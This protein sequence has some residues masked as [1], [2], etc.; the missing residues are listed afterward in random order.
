MYFHVH[1]V[2]LH[3]LINELLSELEGLWDVVVKRVGTHDYSLIT[4]ICMCC[5]ARGLQGYSDRIT[6]HTIIVQV[7]GRTWNVSIFYTDCTL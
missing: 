5:M 4:A 1:I 3:I 7:A 6:V 2:P